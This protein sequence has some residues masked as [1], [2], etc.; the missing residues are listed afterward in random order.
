MVG[1]AWRRIQRLG[2]HVYFDPV[3]SKANPVGGLSRGRSEG[4]WRQVDR[5]RLLEDLEEKLRASV[6]IDEDLW[7][8]YGSFVLSAMCVRDRA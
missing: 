6:R 3:D 7:L 4:P 1:E 2:A 8:Q 5:A